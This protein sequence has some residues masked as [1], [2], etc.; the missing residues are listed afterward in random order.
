[1]LHLADLAEHFRRALHF[2]G[3]VQLVQ[4]QADERR[5]LGLVAAD[6]RTGLRDLDLGHVRLL[7]DRFGLSL[8]FGD[9]GAA[10]AEE[11]GN[12]LAA[13]L[14]NRARARLLLERLEGRADH[15]VRV[16]RAHRLGDDVGNAEALEDRAHRTAGDDACT[17]R[18][19]ADRHAAGTEVAETVVVKR[20]AVAQRNADHRLLRSGSRL[21]D[22]LGNFASLAVTEA[23][24]A[25]AV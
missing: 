23:G 24:A 12:L 9:A 4:A 19:G 16:G 25:L 8:G 20:A 17:R 10:T 14:G 11:V 15:V 22:R 18:S 13:T 1:M 6:R 21:A 3:A 5:A 7:R 2:H